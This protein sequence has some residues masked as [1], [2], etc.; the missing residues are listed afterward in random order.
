MN[1]A[2]NISA[3]H[4]PAPRL[5]AE[6]LLLFG[7]IPAALLLVRHHLNLLV[8]PLVLVA[9][10]S[11]WLWLRR[12]PDFDR[13]KLWNVRD[14]IP[15][16]ARTLLIFLPLGAV[17]ALLSYLCMPQAFFIFPK[18]YFVFWLIVMIGYPILSAYPQELIYRA[19]FYHRYA[20][21][22]RYRWQLV[23]A[24]TILFGWVHIFLG[25]WI[26]PV[27]AAIGGLL[28]SRTYFRSGGILQSAIEHGLWG[29]LLFTVGVGWYFYA[30][31]VG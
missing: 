15:H 22:F 11:C 16:L 2:K 20:P 7:G 6:M 14:F 8:I 12:Q 30:G 23:L 25:N 10:L 17:A 21:L 27:F 19:F 5:W 4:A 3:G 1:D 13:A 28:F 31:S 26:A 24:N 9:A 18:Q 29:D